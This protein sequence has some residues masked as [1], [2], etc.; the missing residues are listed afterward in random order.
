[1][2]CKLRH[3]SI[4]EDL[5]FGLCLIVSVESTEKTKNEHRL[6]QHFIE[7]IFQCYIHYKQSPGL[8]GDKIQNN[9]DNVRAALISVSSNLGEQLVL[10]R[11]T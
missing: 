10:M 11:T 3:K 6:I 5:D 8:S 7:A 2:V 4:R 1:M 9:N